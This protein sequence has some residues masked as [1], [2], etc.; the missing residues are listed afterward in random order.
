MYKT[1]VNTGTMWLFYVFYIHAYSYFSCT[2]SMQDK[3]SWDVYKNDQFDSIKWL[4][5]RRRCLRML[6][7]STSCLSLSPHSPQVMLKTYLGAWVGHFSTLLG[8]GELKVNSRKIVSSV[9]TLITCIVATAV[10]IRKMHH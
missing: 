3:I 7:G 5:V 4:F 8:R 10:K 9:L 6:S 1:C 2:P